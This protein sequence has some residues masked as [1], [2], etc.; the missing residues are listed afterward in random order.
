VKALRLDRTVTFE[1]AAVVANAPDVGAECI[2]RRWTERGQRDIGGDPLLRIAPATYV[3]GLLGVEAH[4][5]RKVPCPFHIDERPSLHVY[6][7]AARGWCCFSCGRG[8]S[9]YDLAAAVWGLGTRGPDFIELRRRLQEQFAR[10]LWRG[11]P[12]LER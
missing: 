11:G 8:G 12:Q 10:Q 7:T 2:Q 5:G 1:A 3:G 9:I 4:P 6:P